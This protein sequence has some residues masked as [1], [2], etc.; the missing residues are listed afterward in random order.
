MLFNFQGLRREGVTGTEKKR[1]HGG[2]AQLGEHL[3]CKQGV[4]S[5]TLLI[6]TSKCKEQSAERKGNCTWMRA[7][8]SA[9]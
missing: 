9:G 8:S 2:V 1:I 6:S 3:P 5:S 4:R 7:Y